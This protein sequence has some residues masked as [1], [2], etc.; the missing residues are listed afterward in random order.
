ME[1]VI[2]PLEGVLHMNNTSWNRSAEQ[3]GKPENL[4]SDL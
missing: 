3:E 2:P 4:T 1:L